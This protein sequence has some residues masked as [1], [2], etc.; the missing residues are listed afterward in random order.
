M[1]DFSGSSQQ[2]HELN[3]P[4][5]NLL[6]AGAVLSQIISQMVRYAAATGP[7]PDAAPIPEAAHA[8]LA[9]ALT[10]LKHRYSRRDLKVATRIL[11]EATDRICEEV[12]FVPLDFSDD[13]ESAGDPR[14]TLE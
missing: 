4:S 13:S 7:V 12:Y 3:G 11:K 10:D 6:G 8:V 14:G 9:D 5:M 2:P 1:S